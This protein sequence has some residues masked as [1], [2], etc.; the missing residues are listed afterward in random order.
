MEGEL[1]LVALSRKA[2]LFFLVDTVILNIALLIAYAVLVVSPVLVLLD[3]SWVLL[4]RADVQ[5]SYG[6]FAGIGAL[7]LIIARMFFRDVPRMC[8]WS[9]SIVFFLCAYRP[10]VQFLFDQGGTLA[11]G[12]LRLEILKGELVVFAGMLSLTVA[13]VFVLHRASET[14]VKGLGVVIIAVAVILGGYGASRFS[15][16]RS[17]HQETLLELPKIE[18][19]HPFA[20]GAIEARPNI[21]Q[22]VL[23]G[24]ATPGNMKR[25]FNEEARDLERYLA[26]AGFYTAKVGRANYPEGLSS[27]ASLMN[28]RYFDQNTEGTD[29]SVLYSYLRKN[30]FVS[31][32]QQLGYRTEVITGSD[33]TEF[34]GATLRNSYRVNELLAHVTGTFGLPWLRGSI[35]KYWHQLHRKQIDYTFD[36]LE[37][38]EVDSEPRYVLGHI[39]SPRPPFVFTRDGDSVEVD[40]PFVLEDGSDYGDREKIYRTRYVDQYSYITARL[41][42]ALDQVKR[43]CNEKCIIVVHSDHGSGLKWQPTLAASDMEERYAVPIAIYFPG[44][45]NENLPGRLSLVNVLRIVLNRAFNQTLPLVPDRFYSSDLSETSIRTA[46]KGRAS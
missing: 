39:A 19:I 10:I 45:N 43:N 42:T 41:I 12:L 5:L 31:K 26:V 4:Q 25:V 11:P 40:R 15:A 23:G 34:E 22:I 21:I 27:M 9:L 18:D 38:F 37:Q 46:V 6:L 29:P 24:Y 17:Q 44:A 2:T 30:A 33:A 35:S 14:L 1:S 16:V 7:F 3:S 28:L 36:Q 32:L 13:L 20:A 8:C